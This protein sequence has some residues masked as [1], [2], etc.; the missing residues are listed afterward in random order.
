MDVP[1]L[2]GKA[3]EVQ[4]TEAKF[5]DAALDLSIATVSSTVLRDLL[6][7]FCETIP[8][9]KEKTIEHLLVAKNEVPPLPDL[10]SKG[11]SDEESDEDE[12]TDK[13]TTA[14]AQQPSGK[15]PRYSQCQRCNKEFDHSQNTRT[16][17]IYHSE[18]AYADHDSELYEDN[19]FFGPEEA[20]SDPGYKE[21]YPEYFIF[22]CC[23][24]NY[25][26]NPDG[27]KTGW[28]REAAPAKKNR[29]FS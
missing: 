29:Y 17:C 7:S 8:G 5:D 28:H 19:D 26:E 15:R 10:D 1:A 12:D 6:K 27:C 16:S 11:E 13:P 18:E 9:V 22:G 3:D 2:I 21:E 4:N 25:R 24:D 14:L 20:N 23:G